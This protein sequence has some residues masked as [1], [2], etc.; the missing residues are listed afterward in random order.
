MP[1]FFGNV[2]CG[3]V[4][5]VG[6][7]SRAIFHKAGA[8]VAEVPVTLLVWS[9]FTLPHSCG[10]LRSGHRLSALELAICPTVQNRGV[11]SDALSS[12]EDRQGR[13]PCSPAT[14]WW[15]T[16]P[17]LVAPL[18]TSAWFLSHFENEHRYSAEQNPALKRGTLAKC[19]L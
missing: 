18:V 11:A 8:S 7:E 3:S 1:A 10:S 4:G 16:S 9:G 6:H 14:R 19:I 5:H 15:P 13:R 2:R 17:G 12:R